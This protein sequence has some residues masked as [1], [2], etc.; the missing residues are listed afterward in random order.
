MTTPVSKV[1]NVSILTSPTFPA[2]RGFGLLNIIGNSTRLPLGDR[3]RFY[4]DMDGVAED[5]QSTDE[6]YK[7]ATL[8]FS[9]APRPVELA[10]SRR[11]TSDAPAE[12][13]GGI[14]YEKDL[15]VWNA[16]VDGGFDITIDGTLNKVAGV[17]LSAASNFNAIAAAIQAKLVTLSIGSTVTYDG[18]RFIVRSGTAGVTSTISYATPPS[19]VSA[20]DD[21]SGMLAI[22]SVG[23]GIITDGADTELITESLDFLQDLNPEWYGFTFT[24]EITEAEIKLAAAWSEARTKIFGYTTAASNVLDQSSMA[25]IASFLNLNK[26]NRTTGIF[27]FSNPYSIISA[28][29]RA[30][31]VNFNA[32]NST[33]TL[34][35]KQLPG[36]VP[37]NLKESQR[38]SVVEKK[39]N[40]YTV[41]GDSAMLAEGVMASGQYFDER[42]GVDWLQNAIE[43]NV[44][45]FLYTRLTKVPQTDKGVASLV[46][47]VELAMQE[48]VNNGLLAPG[49]WNGMDLGE[50]KS[51][52][53]LPRGFYV[54]AQPIALQ[55]QSDREA[56]KAPPIQ[57]LA[58]GAG[59]IHFADILVTF[60]R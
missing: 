35:F 25:D 47:Q 21:I 14:G 52:D 32:A 10:I 31:T 37:S 11:L 6:E 45:G 55:N 43:T 39:E 16:I 54:Y 8:F 22:N 57:V 9:Q 38:L 19:D 29:A 30:F 7:A 28:M 20:P 50:V 12:L 51:G 2:R 13:L 40:Y 48:G 36:V 5:F 44:F 15:A 27:D 23:L 42:H 56:R 49:V 58:K 33:I 34:K 4:A 18:S 46:Q 17:D 59:A 60:E 26:Y 41:F 3:F 24:K 53:Y 1:V